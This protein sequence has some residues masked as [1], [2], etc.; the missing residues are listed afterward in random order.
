MINRGALVWVRAD[1]RQ[2]W[3]GVVFLVL[4]AGIGFGIVLAALGGARRT[5]SAIDRA[6]EERRVA[7]AIVQLNTPEAAEIVLE[8]PQVLEG[9]TADM[10][11]GHIEGIEFDASALVVHGG[12]GTTFDTIELTA[13]RHADPT[14]PHEVVLPAATAREAGVGVGDTITLHTLSPARGAPVHR[15]RG[16]GSRRSGCTRTSDRTRGRRDR[17]D[18]DQPHR[19]GGELHLRDAGL[20]RPLCDDGGPLRGGRHRWRVRSGAAE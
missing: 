15:H 11:L 13:G 7:D 14:S 9:A 8:Q 6:I 16:R 2:R 19:D 20:R 1:L 3:R 12:W 10:Y 18:P 17:R 5:D 4:L